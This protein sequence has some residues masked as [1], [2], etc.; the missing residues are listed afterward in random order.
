V[1]LDGE[2]AHSISLF[3]LIADPQEKNN[4]LSAAPKEAPLRE[5]EILAK[6]FAEADAL[7]ERGS[8]ENSTERMAKLKELGY[9]D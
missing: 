8:V 3:D 9:V 4:Q 1:R 7:F 6:K 2:A 5:L